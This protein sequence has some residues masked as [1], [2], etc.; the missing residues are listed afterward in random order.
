MRQLVPHL[1]P[2]LIWAAVLAWEAGV[3][4][5]LTRH[6]G[7]LSIAPDGSSFEGRYASWKVE[8]ITGT[9]ADV[10]QETRRS[11]YDNGYAS[12]TRTDYYADLLLVGADGRQLPIFMPASARG[13]FV[14]HVLTF[15]YGVRGGRV[16]LFAVLNHTTGVPVVIKLQANRI[17]TSRGFTGALVTTI[18]L[19]SLGIIPFIFIA[20]F[21]AD[22]RLNEFGR[23]GIAPLWRIA[24]P[25]C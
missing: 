6:N 9:V 2:W 24:G 21:M 23:V 25:G 16:H 7:P 14:G 13:I 20:H 15:C 11:T 10:R 4:I 22:D 18:C 3:V 8:T 17:Y 19:V 12:A 1:Y 5:L